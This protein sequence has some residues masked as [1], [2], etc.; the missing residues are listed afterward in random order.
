MLDPLPYRHLQPDRA[1]V[2]QSSVWVVAPLSCR[3]GGDAR[4]DFRSDTEY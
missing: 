2:P 1:R 4:F 3:P